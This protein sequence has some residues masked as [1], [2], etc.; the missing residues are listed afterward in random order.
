M[1]RGEQIVYKRGCDDTGLSCQMTSK[2]V[3]ERMSARLAMTCC[4]TDHCNNATVPFP[5]LAPASSYSYASPNSDFTDSGGGGQFSTALPPHSGLIAFFGVFGL[6]AVAFFAFVF[7]KKWL[8]ARKQR[9]QSLQQ[10]QQT[11]QNSN[12][13]EDSFALD[14]SFESKMTVAPGQPKL[15]YSMADYRSDGI[16][17]SVVSPL[18]SPSLHQSHSLQSQSQ[19]QPISISGDHDHLHHHQKNFEQ[20]SST[21]DY[22]RPEVVKMVMVPGGLGEQSSTLNR[23]EATSAAFNTTST[24]I[25]TNNNNNNNNNSLC[26]GTLSSG[27]GSGLPV[28]IQRTLA[29]EITL[30][31][32][33]G[34]GRY[35]E[36]W[37]GSYHAEKVAVKIFYSRDEASFQ[38]EVEIYSIILMKSENILPFI[39]SDVTSVS[40]C[41]QLWLVTTYYP[42]GS[43]FDYLNGKSLRL[44]EMFTVL[45]SVAAGIAHLHIEYFGVQGKPAI[46]HRDIKSKNILVKAA[47]GTCCIADF[48]LAVTHKQT[49]GS[50]N[51]GPANY[52]VGTKRYMAPEVLSE[53]MKSD[54]FNSYRHADM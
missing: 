47:D 33:I 9:K 32:C 27:S 13:F 28:L 44:R 34:A 43:L 2:I 45:S 38:R 40:S 52:R 7:T 6:L 16:S 37:R 4:S 42:L 5:Q 23:S 8:S 11:H 31:T 39:G 49:T 14:G 36:V 41:T 50:L 30:E 3:N 22:H 19:S 18:L 1:G 12:N 20:Y 54:D 51:I 29:R 10:Q 35:G 48:G 25:T 26:D 15:P 17:G 24:T 53:T 21:F 46:A